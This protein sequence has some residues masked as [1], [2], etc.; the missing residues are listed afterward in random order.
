MLIKI[1]TSD[2]HNI[3]FAAILIFS[4][5]LHAAL[6]SQL[7]WQFRVPEPT[8]TVF[9]VELLKPEKKVIPPR[10]V[11]PVQPKLKPRPAVKKT[12]PKPKLLDKKTAPRPKAGKPE[13]V[14]KKAPEPVKKA[15][16]VQKPLPK[17]VPKPL[18]KPLPKP[19]LNITSEMGQ[20]PD[21]KESEIPG[22]DSIPGKPAVS[23][24]IVQVKPP[25]VQADEQSA[26][27]EDPLPVPV[28]S[29]DPDDLKRVPGKELLDSGQI[30]RSSKGSDVKAEIRTEKE[31][32]QYRII[33]R[34][35]EGGGQIEGSDDSG[36]SMIEGE[37][38]QRK[39]IFKPE[40][41]SL[42]L[43]RDV[44]ITLKFTVLPN[45]EVDQIFPYRKA[46]PALERLAMQLLRQY[47][48]E[49]LFEN[50]KTQHGI[51]HF[52]IYRNK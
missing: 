6:L 51:I 29:V 9:E 12:P 20:S 7:K 34:D 39:V 49:P 11:V 25:E 36:D 3:L 37:L 5:T 24:L 19:S 32:V 21:L 46:E 18:P 27:S 28:L 23:E 31:T 13:A 50:D 52:S 33:D 2:P 1:K 15:V 42:N 8:E 38:R 43:E 41:P 44:T 22:Q 4:I 45:G 30:A 47:R 26:V 14:V 35:G 48:F 17:P 40:P 10:R 16:S